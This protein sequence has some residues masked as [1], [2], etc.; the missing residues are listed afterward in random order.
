MPSERSDIND[1]LD[2]K[3]EMVLAELKGSRETTAANFETV[4][5][6]LKQVNG[7]NSRMITLEQKYTSIEAQVSQLQS[8]RTY[9]MSTL[10]PILIG[11][12]ALLVAIVTL[13]TSLL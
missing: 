9:R 8:G 11:C 6:E 2:A 7:L 5:A 12:L 10:P 3:I 13:A 1:L 4:K